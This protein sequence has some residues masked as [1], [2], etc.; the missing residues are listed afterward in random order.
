MKLSLLFL[1]ISFTAIAGDLKIKDFEWH[2]TDIS[3]KGLTKESLFSR[4]DRDF[5]VPKSSIC[6]NR[7]L[8]WANNFKKNQKL[9][10]GKIFLFYTKKKGEISLKT[11]WY[12]VAPVINENGNVWVMDAGF[13]GFIDSPISTNEWLLKFSSSNNCKEIQSHETELV[14]L[15]FKSWTFP[16]RTS[17]GY[18]DCYYKIVPHTL[19]T[20]EIVAMNILGKNA[21]GEPVRVERH[22]I[23]KDELYQACL[24]ATT[25]KL[26]YALGTNKKECKEYAGLD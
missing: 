19:W 22:E 24:E 16:H 21:S 10:T 9:D 23:D 18:Y 2:L 26:G 25:S 13:P 8:M 15:I 17:Y 20:P 1:L 7:A 5:I 4:M 3:D 6:S 12:H 14:E 11:W